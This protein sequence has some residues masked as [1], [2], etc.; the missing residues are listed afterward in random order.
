MN[1]LV[2]LVNVAKEIYTEMNWDI[3]HVISMRYQQCICTFIVLTRPKMLLET[4]KTPINLVF[5]WPWHAISFSILKLIFLTERD[6]ISFAFFLYTFSESIDGFQ[7]TKSTGP[8]WCDLKPSA[9]R[10]VIIWRNM[11]L[12]Y[13]QTDLSVE[14]DGSPYVAR[15]K[16]IPVS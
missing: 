16:A 8:M 2:V 11:S 10:L 14:T 4:V 12:K 13:T 5:E 1:E 9:H 6:K 7:I 15:N 3:D